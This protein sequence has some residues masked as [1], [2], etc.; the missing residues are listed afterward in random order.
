MLL[1]PC[2]LFPVLCSLS[3]V[4]CLH[5]GLP[6][7]GPRIKGK[8]F[9]RFILLAPLCFPIFVFVL[10]KVDQERAYFLFFVSLN[11][12][13]PR[14]HVLFSIKKLGV[15]ITFLLKNLEFSWLGMRQKL[16]TKICLQ[17][18]KQGST[19]MPIS[20]N[21]GEPN[22]FRPLIRRPKASRFVFLTVSSFAPSV[23]VGCSRSSLTLNPFW[24]WLLYFYCGKICHICWKI[25]N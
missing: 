19:P 3:L 22:K 13:H 21:H 7:L 20:L 1:V 4:P 12:P 9:P 8:S 14:S 25:Q 15:F 2:S 11:P 5:K 23:W 6:T 18:T 24:V 17:W 10:A 16:R